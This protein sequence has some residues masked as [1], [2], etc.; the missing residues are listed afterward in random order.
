MLQMGYLGA[1]LA[2][3]SEGERCPLCLEK[4]CDHNVNIKTDPFLNMTETL[5]TDE[6][7]LKY[8]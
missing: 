2:R 8:A 6:D 3:E 1:K 4:K 7:K 5:N